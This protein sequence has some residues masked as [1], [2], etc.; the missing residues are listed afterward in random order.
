MAA[1]TVIVELGFVSALFSRR[2]RLVMVPAAFAMLIGIRVLMGP[3]FGG[4]LIANVFWVPW[5]V[6]VDAIASRAAP[7]RQPAGAQTAAT[8]A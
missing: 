1:A 6:V 2:A 4:F 3:T 8:D 7:R 5:T